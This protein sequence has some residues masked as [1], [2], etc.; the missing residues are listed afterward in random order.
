M[1]SSEKYLIIGSIKEISLKRVFIVIIFITNLMGNENYGWSVP[2][3][4]LNIGG[5]LDMTYDMNEEPKF[6]FDDISLLVSLN[7]NR[8]DFLAEIEFSHISLDGRSNGSQDVD[9]N[10][11]R[12]Q[13]SYMFGDREMLR[14]GRF[15][16]NIG[17]WNLA[18]IPILENTTSKPHF[19]GK[20]FP[21][22][23]AGAMV[24]EQIN[25]GDRLSFSLQNSSD[26]THQEDSIGAD[27]HLLLSYYGE[28]DDLSWNIAFGNYREKNAKERVNYGGV[29]LA[30]EGESID[31]KSEL[32]VKD[33]G[34]DGSKPYSGYAEGAW[35]F[36]EQ[37]D[38]VVRAEHYKESSSTLEESIYLLGY[39]YRPTKNMALKA[40]YIEH[41]VLPL[42]H[43]L[44]SFSVLF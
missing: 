16:T 2:N 21:R 36:L 14:V 42:N 39:V 13:L 43:F 6:L 28:R 38:M 1:K 41:S 35:H 8:F 44:Y 15:N 20:I 23:M 29:S 5:Y 25:N 34:E 33:D 37:H 31:L 27:S 11:E 7:Q 3:S 24:E 9:L 40:E 32:Y 18:P 4:N 26:F 10:I 17:F 30:Y 12:L 22:Y 19:V